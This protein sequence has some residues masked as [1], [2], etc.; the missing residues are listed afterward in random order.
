M[1]AALVPIPDELWGELP[2]AFLQLRPGHAATRD[3]AMSVIE[4]AGRRLAR[5]KIPAYVEFVEEFTLTPSAR[6]EKRHLLHPGRD[7][8]AAPAI[9]VDK[10]QR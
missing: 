8:R 1:S 6:I 5:F 3:T 7:Q 9:Q 4:H 2:K 10:E